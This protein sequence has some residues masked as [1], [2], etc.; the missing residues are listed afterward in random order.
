L[1]AA[2]A[3]DPRRSSGSHQGKKANSLREHA[4]ARS[5]TAWCPRESTGTPKRTLDDYVVHSKI[6]FGNRLNLAKLRRNKLYRAVF[7][8]GNHV[9]V[10][11]LKNFS[12]VLEH[13]AYETKKQDRRVATLTRVEFLTLAYTKR[14][15]E[16]MRDTK[17]AW[18]KVKA[19]A[20]YSVLLFTVRPCASAEPRYVLMK[21]KYGAPPKIKRPRTP[22]QQAVVDK[23]KTKKFSKKVLQYLNSMRFLRPEL[24]PWTTRNCLF[25]RI[26][27]D[28]TLE[29][30]DFTI[31]Y[32]NKN[33]G[34]S[35][36]K[37]A[38]P[39]IKSGD[40]YF[41]R[42]IDDNAYP[43][44]AKYFWPRISEQDFSRVWVMAYGGANNNKLDLP[45]CTKQGCKCVEGIGIKVE[46]VAMLLKAPLL[47]MSDSASRRNIRAGL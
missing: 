34:Q 20:L 25:D 29:R 13:D 42:M 6:G 9:R 10:K 24:K 41:Q 45:T 8:P 16:S 33:I 30:K 1:S 4:L 44:K 21:V 37:L 12:D 5:S 2:K 32:I 38:R 17:F 28:K 46:T 18:R 43:D 26:I 35:Q 39:L 11:P 23:A 7:L 14:E 27:Q 19:G 47:L 3:I 40:K 31:Q 22:S 15:A 36:Y